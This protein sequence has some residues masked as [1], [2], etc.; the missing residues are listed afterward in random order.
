MG[1]VSELLDRAIPDRVSTDEL[2]RVEAA[3]VDYLAGRPHAWVLA[4]DQVPAGVRARAL[5]QAGDGPGAR[6]AL[7]AMAD[8]PASPQATAAAVW[9]GSR[10]GLGDL[11]PVLR[12]RVDSMEPGFVFE[13]GTPLGLSLIHI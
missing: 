4:S 11:A 10:V 12:A 2:S 13:S 7:A 3:E 1:E 9:A 8:E 6:Q 5:V